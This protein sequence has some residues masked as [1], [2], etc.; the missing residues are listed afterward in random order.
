MDVADLEPG[1]VEV[2]GQVFGHALGQG[3]DQHAITGGDGVLTFSD[4]VVDLV[5]GRA[6]QARRVEQPGRADD[7]LGEH[8]ARALKL[9]GVGRGGNV[10]RLRAHGVP[11]FEFERAV[12]LARGQAEAVVAER[13]LARA[14]ALE[15]GADLGDRHVAF[16][17]DEQGVF[18]QVFEQGR[19]RLTGRASGQIPA[20]VLDP[21]ADAGRLHH[22]QIEGAALLQALG[23]EQ[24]AVGFQLLEPQAEVVLDVLERLHDRRLGRHVVGVGIQAGLLQLGGLFPGQRVDF[25][26][27]FDFV[28]EE[29]QAPGAV[30]EVGR[31][32]LDGVP[33]DAEGATLEADIVAPVL[34]LDEAA[35][36]LLLRDLGANLEQQGH[37]GVGLRRAHTIDAGHRGDDDDVAALEQGPRRRVA[38]AVDLLVD[39]GF[40]VDVG[41]RTG[42]VGLGLIVVVVG[43]EVLDRVVGEKLLH[44]AVELGGEG[45]V[46]RHDQRRTLQRLDDVSHGEGLARTG[47]AEQDVVAVA[48]AQALEQVI[49]GLGLVAGRLE[50]GDDLQRRAF[51]QRRAVDRVP[52]NCSAV[53]GVGGGSGCAGGGLDEGFG[54]DKAGHADPWQARE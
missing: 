22:L 42:D 33:P 27:A 17:D 46:V 51:I 4:Q 52:S 7:L 11:L 15:H 10:D 31:E 5:V 14:V 50:V 16:V 21:R 12:V 23:L 48:A 28:T 37:G 36:H 40:L 24:L 32:D 1:F 25:P 45:L 29:R 39:G 9:P 53:I 44:L 49:D 13:D 2:V 26:D 35:Q 19:G 54:V 38:H 41:V 6:D 34:Q 8:T 20:V 47:N 3:G 30:F 43:H 18:G